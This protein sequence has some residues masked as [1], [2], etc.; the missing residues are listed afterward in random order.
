M[1]PEEKLFQKGGWEE[2]KMS[3]YSWTGLYISVA[4]LTQGAD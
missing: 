2:A 3:Q 4:I 1:D